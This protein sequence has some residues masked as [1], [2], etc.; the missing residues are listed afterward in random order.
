MENLE[1][2]TKADLIWLVK[3]IQEYEIGVS[4]VNL[5]L[6]DLKQKKAREC[7]KKAE[8]CNKRSGECLRRYI[9]LMK[10]YEGKG[11]LEIPNDVWAKATKEIEK[12]K[13]FDDQYDEHIRAFERWERFGGCENAD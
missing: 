1:K 5:A 13:R 11:L 4:H 7:L 10:P 8:E 9:D 6:F 2:Y 3:K 12:K